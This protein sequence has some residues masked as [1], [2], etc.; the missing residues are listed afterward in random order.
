MQKPSS[1]AM[2]PLRNSAKGS[3]SPKKFGLL[4][5]KETWFLSPITGARVNVEDVTDTE[6]F[7]FIRQYVNVEGEDLETWSL[8]E[9]RDVLNF[10]LEHGHKPNFLEGPDAAESEVNA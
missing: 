8:E 4:D 10:A 1:G 7:Q 3:A 9:R 6:F 5:L 2:M